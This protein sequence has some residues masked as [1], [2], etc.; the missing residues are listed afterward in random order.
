MLK[1]TKDNYHSLQ[2]EREYMSRS[3]YLGFLDCEAR[4]MA[5]LAGEWVEEK[6]KALLVG[7]YVHAWNEG[8]RKEFIAE[9]PEMFTKAG[10]LRADFKVA[11]KMIDT[12]ENDPLC[13]YMLEGEKEQIFTAE[14]AGTIWK[15]MADVHN[16]NRQRMID[17]KT[18]KSIREHTW[19]DEQRCKLSFVEQYNYVL[20]AALYCEI[21]KIAKKRNSWLDFY[22]V[23]V[24]KENSPDKAV[25]D[26][27]DPERY[28]IELEAVKENMPHILAVKLGKVEPTRCEKCEYCRSTKKLTG[29]V[30]YIDL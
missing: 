10:G 16:P 8:C 13:M 26:L 6:S 18:T 22:I 17:L 19:N 15:V 29:A 25:I 23:A 21:E 28:L 4:E 11:D 7:S 2:A 24:S 5:K 30:H 12:L 27:R 3:Q 14:F 1:L 9:T 20:Q